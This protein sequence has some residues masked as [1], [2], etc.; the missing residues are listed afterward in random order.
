L[1]LALTQATNNNAFA[2]FGVQRPNLVG[3]PVPNNP[4]TAMWFNTAA[5]QAAPQ[6]TIGT[7]SRNPVRAPGVR[8]MDLALVKQTR[9][10]E[11]VNM[12][13]RSEFFNFTNTP[14]LNA[15]AV[16]LGNAGFGSITSAGDPRVI[17]FAM[18]VT[19]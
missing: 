17:Q 19:F 6:F 11:S 12:E 16:V 2:G 3:N 18:K 14:P 13:F 4:S 5:F 15:P 10:T 1:P 8:N 7:S 9:L